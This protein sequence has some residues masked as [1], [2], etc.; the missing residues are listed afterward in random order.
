MSTK[1]IEIDGSHGEGGGQILRT[2]LSLAAILRK[3]LIISNI[4]AGR[5][6]PGLQPQHLTGVRAVAEIC[7]GKLKGDKLGSQEI[8]FE[9]GEIK[10][11]HY[12]FDVMKVK[13]SAGSTG[14]IFQQ[15][16]PVL[17]FAKAKSE[18]ILKG[19]THTAWAPPVDYLERVL[20]PTIFDMGLHAKLEIITYGWYPMG[21]GEVKAT[22]HPIN[23]SLSPIDLS[24]RGNLKRIT[25]N[26]VVTNLPMSIAERQKIRAWGKLKDHKLTSEIKC[27]SGQGIGAGTSILLVAEF[28]NSLAGF[29]ALGKP[30]KPAEDVADEAVNELLKFYKS[31]MCIEKYLSDQLILYMALAE[32]KS[33]FTVSEI[34]NHLLT[35][36]WVAEQFLGVKFEVKG[37]LG[38]PGEAAVEGIALHSK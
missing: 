29:S 7:N 32:G 23:G 1:Q 3:K 33:N 38:S 10:S 15:I 13:S 4:R 8:E 17:G 20:L 14:M 6:K 25:G 12:E 36:I 19:G 24:D 31:K 34:S 9:P 11:E 26:S 22:I 2:A 16:A 18:I 37:N 30:G 28:E 5:R 35:S 21:Q 27:V